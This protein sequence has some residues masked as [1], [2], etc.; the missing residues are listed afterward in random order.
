MWGARARIR[1][2]IVRSPDQKLDGLDAILRDAD[3][4]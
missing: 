1:G 3:K 2:W 4:A